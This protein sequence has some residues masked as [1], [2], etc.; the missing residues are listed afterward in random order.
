V[1]RSGRNEA[2]AAAR[3][4]VRGFAGAPDPR[5]HAH[6]IFSELSHAE[7]WTAQEQALVAELG[8]WLQDRPNLGELKARCEATLARLR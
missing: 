5:K 4:L 7:G 1:F 8:A 2:L 3:K 6:R